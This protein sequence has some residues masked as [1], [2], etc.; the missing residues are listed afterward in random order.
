MNYE[1]YWDETMLMDVRGQNEGYLEQFFEYYRI[2]DYRNTLIVFDSLSNILRQND[3]IL[4]IKAMALMESG[5]TE[6]PK[7][8][9]INI[10]DHKRSRYIYQSEWYLALLFLKEKNIEK[11]NQLLNKI[12]IDK[13]SLYRNKAENLLR[14]VQLITSESKKNE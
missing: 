1:P 6:N 11:A 4:F 7:S 8:I 5:E 12:K 9:F 2:K 3:N 10:I 14:K 13:Q